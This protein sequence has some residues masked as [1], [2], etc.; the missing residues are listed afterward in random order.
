MIRVGYV[1]ALLGAAIF[2]ISAAT[3]VGH[4]TALD[5]AARVGAGLLGLGCAYVL[6]P[7]NGKGGRR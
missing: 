6:R 7:R 5:T 4:N 3:G 1:L 2:W